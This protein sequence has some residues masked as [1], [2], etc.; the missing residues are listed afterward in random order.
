MV[1]DLDLPDMTGFELIAQIKQSA[2]VPA[3]IVVY[4]SKELH[5]R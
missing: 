1:L 5:P 3:P 4:S 2:R